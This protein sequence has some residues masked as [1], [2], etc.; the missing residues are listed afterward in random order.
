MRHVRNCYWPE[1]IEKLAPATVK[2]LRALKRL[3]DEDL[4][5]LVIGIV[6]IVAVMILG[7]TS[8]L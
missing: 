8:F 3:E 2:L 4:Y 7:R 6:T 5:V 1:D